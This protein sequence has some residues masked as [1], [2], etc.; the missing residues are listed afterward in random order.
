VE[1]EEQRSALTRLRC[2]E[3]QGWIFSEAVP[4]ESFARLLIPAGP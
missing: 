2:D 1:T 4:E 3:M